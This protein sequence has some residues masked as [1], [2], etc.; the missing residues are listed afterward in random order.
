MLVYS[1]GPFNSIVLESSHLSSVDL[2]TWVDIAIK[3]I[4]RE[5]SK[6]M[7]YNPDHGADYTKK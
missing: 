7:I 6:V 5:P 2:N 4:P 1:S 3:V